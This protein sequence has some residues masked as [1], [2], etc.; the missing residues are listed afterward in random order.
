MI[1]NELL[2]EK[3]D[4]QKRMSHK[5]NYDI[6]KLLDNAEEVVKDMLRKHGTSLKIADIKPTVLK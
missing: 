6:K 1:T 2:K 3:W 5:A 4:T